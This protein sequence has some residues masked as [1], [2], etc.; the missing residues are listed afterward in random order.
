L[1]SFTPATGCTPHLVAVC[2]N[3]I[4]KEWSLQATDTAKW[5][6]KGR[7]YPFFYIENHKLRPNVQAVYFDRKAAT[8]TKSL[9]LALSLIVVGVAGS[10]ANAQQRYAP[11]TT[12]VQKA[13]VPPDPYQGPHGHY[14]NPADFDRSLNGTPCGQE[15]T[16]RARE[17]WGEQGSSG[18]GR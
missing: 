1:P 13:V 11:E 12:P 15:C 7:N 8:M 9:V 18:D 14:D 5:I 2:V 4:G 17:R 10:V 6:K 3:R 16:Q